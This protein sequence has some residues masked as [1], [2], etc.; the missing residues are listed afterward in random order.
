MPSRSYIADDIDMLT[1]MSGFFF[2]FVPNEL[3]FL[4]F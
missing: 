4:G 2:P 3:G 1:E